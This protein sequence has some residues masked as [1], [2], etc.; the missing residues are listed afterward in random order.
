MSRFLQNLSCGGIENV[1]CLFVCLLLFVVVCQAPFSCFVLI[2]IYTV[3]GN[4][5]TDVNFV[6]DI[7]VYLFVFY[8]FYR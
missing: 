1:V 4:L 2:G 6:S 7:F 8:L 5:V 3:C